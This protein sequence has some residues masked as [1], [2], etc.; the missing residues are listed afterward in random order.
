VIPAD[1]RN[2]AKS[3]PIVADSVG[4]VVDAW[5]PKDLTGADVVR[6]AVARHLAVELYDPGLAGHAVPRI[7]NVL[8]AVVSALDGKQEV[9]PGRTPTRAELSRLLDLVNS[10]K[11]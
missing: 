1:S 6:G 7:A 3:S 5:L 8:I 9:A 4:G 2:G 11:G 10:T